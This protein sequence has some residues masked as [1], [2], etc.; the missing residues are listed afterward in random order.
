MKTIRFAIALACVLSL[1]GCGEKDKSGEPLLV[2]VGGTMRPVF[3]ELAKTYE[4]ET[5]QKVDINSAGSGEL[6]A[7][8]ELQAEGDLYVC[9]DPFLDIIMHR[10]LAIDGWTVAEIYPVIIV[11]EG[12]PKNIQTLEDL[13]RKDVQLALTDYKLSTLGR[14]LPTIFNKAGMDIH[15][16]TKE[17]NIIIHRSGSYVAN[18]V[19]MNNADAALVWEAVAVLRKEE[20]DSM[21]ITKY[22]PVPWVDTVT[23][24]TGKDYKLAPVRVT[25]CSLKCAD[26][27]KEGQAFIDFVTSKRVRDIL[28]GYGF[29]VPADLRKQE[30]INGEKAK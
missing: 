27:P 14:M 12:N 24:A 18:L 26:Q 7:N 3:E 4:A 22:L 9:H 11:Q 30:Y 15:K 16:I 1:V 13:T 28:E 19:S 10:Q 25:I 20:V 6:L 29:G 2:H 17:K 5:G 23:S 21:P 8:I